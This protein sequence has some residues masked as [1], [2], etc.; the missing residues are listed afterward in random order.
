MFLVS[1]T[2]MDV[3]S[4]AALAMM[5]GSFMPTENDPLSQPLVPLITTI[6]SSTRLKSAQSNPKVNWIVSRVYFTI[7][8]ILVAEASP[9]ACS[10]RDFNLSSIRFRSVISAC[11]PT[12]RSARPSAVRVVALP[13]P[14]IHFHSPPLALMRYSTSNFSIRLFMQSSFIRIARS[15]SSGCKSSFHICM[16]S[17]SSP[18]SYPRIRW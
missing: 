10:W 2:R 12:I 7:S 11:V 18:G 8:S 13:L 6:P 9:N 15:R 3:I 1:S 5:L 4:R 16:L 14:R 17:C